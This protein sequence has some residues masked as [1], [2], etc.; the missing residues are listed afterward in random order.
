MLFKRDLEIVAENVVPDFLH[1]V[2]V[3]DD[4]VLNETGRSGHPRADDCLHG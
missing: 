2:P 4:I 1:V 3:R